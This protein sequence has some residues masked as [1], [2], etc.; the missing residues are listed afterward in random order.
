MARNI[1]I[2]ALLSADE[3]VDYETE[4]AAADVKT[5]PLIR[6][7]LRHWTA[8]QKNKRFQQQREWPADGQH[9]AMSLPG[10]VA[11][12]ELQLQLCGN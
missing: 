7:F 10:R 3:F 6:A 11:P 4:R 1:E 12:H 2:K 5:S 8:E 9:M